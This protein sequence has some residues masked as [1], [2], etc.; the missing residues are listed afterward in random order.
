MFKR[1]K[2]TRR[3]AAAVL[4]V[5]AAV[6]V[7]SQAASAASG[8]WYFASTTDTLTPG[9]NYAWTPVVSCGQGPCSYSTGWRLQVS[10][11]NGAGFLT[12]EGSSLTLVKGTSGAWV[13]S[14]VLDGSTRMLCAPSGSG[15]IAS[16][17]DLRIDG[18]LILQSPATSCTAS[19]DA[20]WYEDV[21]DRKPADGTS[22]DWLTLYT[23]GR[24]A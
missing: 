21:P 20:T 8:N 5:S 16:G 7:C 23:S 13:G 17:D 1:I 15:S 2:L 11:L 18:N 6:L 12:E 3:T 24:C 19:A 4:A 22:D 9:S 14:C 10:A